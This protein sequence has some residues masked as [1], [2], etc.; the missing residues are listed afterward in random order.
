MLN[1]VRGTM[2][3]LA[4]SNNGTGMLI[5]LKACGLYIVNVCSESLESPSGVCLLSVPPKDVKAQEEI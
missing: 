4:A 2:T 3:V 5:M 1:R